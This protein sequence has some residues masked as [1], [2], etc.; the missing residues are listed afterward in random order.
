MSFP[1]YAHGVWCNAKLWRNKCRHCSRE[2]FVFLCD[3]DCRILLEKSDGQFRLHECMP[4]L[5]L[6]SERDLAGIA[7]DDTDFAGLEISPGMNLASSRSLRGAEVN[8]LTEE[9][10]E[11]ILA[12][13]W[14]LTPVQLSFLIQPRDGDPA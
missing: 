8:V 14:D 12:A 5:H 6:F 9:C 7:Q 2:I 13:G 11:K 3:C 4:D 1:D 10:L